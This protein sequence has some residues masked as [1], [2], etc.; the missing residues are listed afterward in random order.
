VN[1]AL[2]TLIPELHTPESL[3][4][5]LALPAHAGIPLPLMGLLITD[6]T[7]RMAGGGS[8][9]S[10]RLLAALNPEQCQEIE[11]WRAAQSCDRCRGA[12]GS[13]CWHTFTLAGDGFH[14][15]FTCESC[16]GRPQ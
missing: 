6:V 2:L 5:F 10:E 1:P 15:S 7:D 4:E 16:L 11:D 8:K 12:A 9:D 13:K 3:D 14:N